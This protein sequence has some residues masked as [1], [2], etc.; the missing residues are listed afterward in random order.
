VIR[1]YADPPYWQTEIDAWA[2]LYGEKRVLLWYTQRANQ[3]HAAC[4]RLLT[5]VLKADSGFTH[6]GCEDTAAHI[7]A[8]RKKTP[9]ANPQGRY[10]LSK[11]GDGRKIDLAV[12]SILCHEAAGE[13]TAA[14]LW[15][16][17]NYVYSA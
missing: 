6:D 11:P 7:G 10:V 16:R 1:L 17:R 3:M 13:V 9:P 4:E 14:K 8:A 15:R 5:D 2:A 12:C